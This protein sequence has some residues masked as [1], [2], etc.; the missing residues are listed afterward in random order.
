MQFCC[1]VHLIKI[2]CNFNHFAGADSKARIQELTG[3][4]KK[5]SGIVKA[6]PGKVLKDDQNQL[7]A[8]SFEKNG[9]VNHI[10]WFSHLRL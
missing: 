7:S 2:T 6:I 5:W 8:V 10:V 3:F 1:L 9:I 4:V